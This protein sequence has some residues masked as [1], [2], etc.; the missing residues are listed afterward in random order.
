MTLNLNDAG[1][2]VAVTAINVR[3]YKM[4]LLVGVNGVVSGQCA[5][6][7]VTDDVARLWPAVRDVH[8]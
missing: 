2:C 4:L 5:A 6:A 1:F 7:T 8:G 3:I